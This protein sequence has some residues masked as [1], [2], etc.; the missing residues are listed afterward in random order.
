ML[1]SHWECFL[2]YSG[3]CYIMV[4]FLK[5][6]Q[7][8]FKPGSLWMFFKILE[9]SP[10]NPYFLLKPSGGHLPSKDMVLTS[11]QYSM[12]FLPFV[13][14]KF[15]A[16]YYEQNT[17]KDYWFYGTK[18]SRYSL[19]NR[20]VIYYYSNGEPSNLVS[21]G[22]IKTVIGRDISLISH[23]ILNVSYYSKI[24]SYRNF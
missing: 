19:D 7:G 23:K 22:G 24:D 3:I 20:N 21:L 8:F 11:S 2:R 16:I 9:A 12:L 17:Y 14:S 6:F 13:V 5:N 10:L 15:S 4:P 18:S 1:I